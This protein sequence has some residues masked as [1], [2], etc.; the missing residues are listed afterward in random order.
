MNLNVRLGSDK[1]ILCWRGF[2]DM[3]YPVVQVP[4]PRTGFTEETSLLDKASPRPRLSLRSSPLDKAQHQ[5]IDVDFTR[6]TRV[7]VGW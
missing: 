7:L 5:S 3:F 2:C 6:Y 4:P 1:S